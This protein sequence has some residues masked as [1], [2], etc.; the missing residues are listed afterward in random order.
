[1]IKRM[2]ATFLSFGLMTSSTLAG[3][4]FFTV[5]VR[6]GAFYVHGV[7]ADASIKQNPLCYAQ[8]EWKDGSEF[9]L[10]RD[11][12]DAELYIFFKNHTWTINDTPDTYQM[13]INFSKN[14]S[15]NGGM[16]INYNLVNKNTI[17]IRNL[18]KDKFVSMFMN[19]SKMTMIMPGTI[20]NAELDLAGSNKAIQEISNCVDAAKKVDLFPDEG[21]QPN[22]LPK[23]KINI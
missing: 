3:E 16:N 8:V 10:I 22:D 9:Q 5:D 21:A 17:V 2:I 14:G 23:G 4:P 1:M 15:L 11:L 7:K 12:A 6:P 20:Q 18:P 13:R 19:S